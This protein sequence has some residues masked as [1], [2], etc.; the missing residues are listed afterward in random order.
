MPKPRKEQV[1]LDATPY[2][3]CVSRCVRRA[4][5]CGTDISTQQNF[6]HR[7]G[8]LENELLKQAQVF[9]IDI[10]AYAIMSNHYHVVLH[11]NKQQADSWSFDDVIERWHALYKGNVLS[12]RYYV[13]PNFSQAEKEKLTEYVEVWRERLMNISWFMRRLNEIISRKANEEDGC[14]GHFWEGRFKSQALLDEQALAACLAYVDLNPIRSNMAKSPETSD[15][16]SAKNRIIKAKSAHAANHPHQQVKGLLVFAGNPKQNMPAGLPFKLTDYLKLLDWTG[17][18]IREDKRGAI[19]K[20]L[21][22]ILQRL[23]INADNW[24]EITQTI[25]RNFKGFIGKPDSLNNSLTHF[26]RQRRSS[27]QASHSLLS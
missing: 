26:N 27:I 8:W 2:Y 22:P 24:I 14:T 18:I 13:D 12:Q 6:E 25:E 7:R 9:A 4:F 5:L 15:Y 16:T 23:N 10:A 21:P 17:R 20:T 3:H 11:I 19:S 1:S